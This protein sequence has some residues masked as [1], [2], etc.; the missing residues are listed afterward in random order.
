VLPILLVPKQAGSIL[1]ADKSALQAD[2][3]GD[4]A[5]GQGQEP[6]IIKTEIQ[7]KTYST[8][9]RAKGVTVHDDEVDADNAE[10]APY[11]VKVQKTELA[12]ER[13]ML[14]REVRVAA[15]CAGV[16]NTASPGTKWDA[17]GGDPLADSIPAILT[18][19]NAIG[20]PPTDAVVPWEVLQYL[21]NNDKLK[22]FF[23]GGATTSQMALLSVDA[24]RAIFGLKRIHVPMAGKL[25]SGTMIAGFKSGTTSSVWGDN[26][27]FFYRPDAPGRQ[28]V[29]FGYTYRWRN[30][31]RGAATN[32]KGQVVTEHYD[33]RKRTLFID[34][35]TYSDEQKLIDEAVYTLTNVLASI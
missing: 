7:D 2:A 32:E 5:I 16:T 1:E 13:L 31:F 24:L 4:D 33:E 8:K 19:K 34:A 22:A 29:A 10:E 3:G 30:A 14:N 26:V 15:I 23:N 20:V 6:G 12:T 28:Q 21:R 18:I 25:A 17:A 9:E 11:E 27:T 35:R